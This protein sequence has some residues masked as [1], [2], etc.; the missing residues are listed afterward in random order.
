MRNAGP[1]WS[2]AVSDAGERAAIDGLRSEYDMVVSAAAGCSVTDGITDVTKLILDEI[3]SGGGALA[4]AQISPARKV[5][6]DAPCH[7]QHAQDIHVGGLLEN[8]DGI[9]LQELPGADRCCGAGG[10]YMAVSADLA[11][12]VRASKLDAIEQ[13]GADIV[14]TA[15]PGCMFWLWRG[16]CER[17]LSIEVRHPVSLIAEA[18]RVHQ[19]AR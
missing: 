14:A 13:S 8:I 18:L 17:G 11:R 9:K 4:G 15:N 1:C 5:V 3:A 12:D 6:W 16:L 10:L 19:T 2:S 7:L